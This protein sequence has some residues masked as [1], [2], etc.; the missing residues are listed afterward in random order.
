M[1][2]GER[3][4]QPRLD[5]PRE[6]RRQVVPRPHYSPDAFGSFAETI[7][8]FIGTARFLVIQTGIIIVWILW[9]VVFPKGNGL[10]FD[11]YPFPFLTL[12]LSLQAAYAAPLI[13]L[14]QNRQADR[15]KGEIER[16]R[17][18]NARSRADMDYLA[19]EIAAIRIA[20][21]GKAD[22]DDMAAIATRLD[23]VLDRLPPPPA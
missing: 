23:E 16:D 21:A 2:R 1:A 9:N 20:L 19:R 7:A 4:R 17:E 10:S 22:R 18:A 11:P 6:M 5:Q 8:R 12:I 13:L 15:D 14:A 3:R